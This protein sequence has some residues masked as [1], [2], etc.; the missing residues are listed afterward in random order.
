MANQAI[1]PIEAVGSVKSKS[2]QI[3][4]LHDDA[5]AQ[6]SLWQKVLADKQAAH[7]YS[8]YVLVLEVVN[9]LSLDKIDTQVVA[10]SQMMDIEH[11]M[12][13]EMI[14]ISK[15]ISELQS[16]SSGTVPYT[17]VSASSVFSWD[18]VSSPNTYLGLKADYYH[19]QD[20]QAGWGTEVVGS[21]FKSSV[22]DF[23]DAFKKLFYCNSDSNAPTVGSMSTIPNPNV[24]QN[25]K[26]FDLTSFWS[27]LQG[28]YSTY[29]RSYSADMSG[30]SYGEAKTFN[31]FGTNSNDHASL[32]Q[33]Y[34]YY[35]AQLAVQGSVD[36][37]D[38]AD[39]DITK[40]V[41]FSPT[42]GD[43]FLQQALGI[44]DTFNTTESAKVSDKDD[45]KLTPWMNTSSDSV[46]DLILQD[47]RNNYDPPGVDPG[48]DHWQA[49]QSQDQKVGLYGAFSDMGFNYY[50]AKAGSGSSSQ[51]MPQA[52]QV[53]PENP[54]GYWE[55]NTKL[56]GVSTGD[57]LTSSYT[58]VNGVITALG[59][60]TSSESVQMQN[61][62]ANE[63]ETVNIAQNAL[64]GMNEAIETYSGNQLSS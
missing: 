13:S 50:W 24:F 19:I 61:L 58:G 30:N 8:C 38:A 47:Q 10:E 57:D 62:T 17:A 35:K 42:T 4:A 44:V 31:V 21:D 26:D 37:V 15:F 39:G 33:Q 52:P 45:N 34:V 6:E 28:Q 3:A 32:I 60:V 46:L 7:K 2:Q 55:E 23:T 41:D 48:N 59:T 20:Q 1:E 53:Y 22:D 54:T 5:I 40:L 36:K 9:H 64:K 11:E 18:V 56:S 14:K 25:G 27:N 49:N 43:S 29:N 16:Q 63:G 12:Q 51:H